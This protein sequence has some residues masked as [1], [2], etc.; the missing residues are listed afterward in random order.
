MGNETLRHLT[1]HHHDHAI[2]PRH[3]V[4]QVGDQRCGDVVGQVGNERD[5]IVGR[6]DF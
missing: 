2:D 5:A 4:E 1:L 6:H 3:L